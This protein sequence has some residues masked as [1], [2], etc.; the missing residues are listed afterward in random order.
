MY[1]HLRILLF[2]F[3]ESNTLV[4]TP[5]RG[6]EFNNDDEVIMTDI[7]QVFAIQEYR[8][9]KKRMKRGSY[10]KILFAN[11]KRDRVNQVAGTF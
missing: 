9:I 11:E 7:E 4:I 10:G 5:T 2:Y 8:M 6:Y 3:R 1:V